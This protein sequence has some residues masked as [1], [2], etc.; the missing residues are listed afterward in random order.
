VSIAFDFMNRMLERR[1]KN[2]MIYLAAKIIFIV[3]LTVSNTFNNGVVNFL[4]SIIIA[5]FMGVKL[6]LGNK[7]IIVLY[8]ACL[9]ICIIA[10]EFVSIV[11]IHFLFQIFNINI[12]SE[13]ISAF[14]DIAANQIIVIFLYLLVLLQILKKRDIRDLTY[15]Q[16]FIA[17]LY[18]FFSLINLYSLYNLL[19]KST[20]ERE[21]IL[22]IITY[23]G[24]VFININFLNILQFMAEVNRLQYEN[25]FFTEQSRMQ[26]QYYDFLEQQYRESLSMLHD[27]KRHIWAIE[28]LYKNNENEKAIDYTENISKIMHS[29]EMNDFTDN[30]M[31]NIILNDKLRLAE[32]KNI[33]FTCTIDNN[34]NLDFMDNIDLT[35]IFANL[36]DNAMEACIKI[37]NDKNIMV[38]VGAFN[39]LI[40][41]TIKN[42]MK[43]IPEYIGI[44]MK[45]SKKNHRGYGL[46]NVNKVIDK[47]NGDFDIQREGNMFVCNI[48]LSKQGRIM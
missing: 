6:Y 43:D 45:S 29:F 44:D 4:S 34:I 1:Y 30:R 10:C 20:T 2:N 15:K 48:V 23:T 42:S 18:S 25:N 16:Y 36:L 9:I 28:E 24:I 40:V 14:F 39:N 31:L 46:N 7:K 41:I 17:L 11:T 38:Y 47:Y 5:G 35:T 13:K 21:L 27:V 3:I 12:I 37:P 8:N 26:Y 33:T 19:N 32:Q 22:V